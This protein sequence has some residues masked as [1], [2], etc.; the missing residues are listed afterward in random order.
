MLALIVAL[1][2]LLLGFTPMAAAGWALGA[3]VIEIIVYQTA[4]VLVGGRS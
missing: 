1:V 3:L 4:R 2:L